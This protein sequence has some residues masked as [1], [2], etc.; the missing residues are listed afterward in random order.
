[1]EAVIAVSPLRVTTPTLRSSAECRWSVASPPL[2][3]SRES[4]RRWGLAAPLFPF[5]SPSPQ[6]P[7][8]RRSN[9]ISSP[10]AAMKSA[11]AAQLTAGKPLVVVGSANADVYV[12]VARM[13]LAGETVSATS[14]CTLPG[15]KGA[16]QAAAGARLG[17]PT[18][19]IGQVGS[20]ANGAMMSAALASTGVHVD[21]LVTLGAPASASSSAAMT[22]A[23]PCVVA[24]NAAKAEA[25]AALGQ[26]HAAAQRA[27]QAA[28]TASR[29]SQAAAGGNFRTGA[30]S[31]AAATAQAEAEA[32]AA[33]QRAAS[34]AARAAAEAAAAAD[35]QSE[36]AARG[37]AA[38]A[39]SAATAAANMTG[40]GGDGSVATGQAIV[41]LQADGSNAIIIVGGANMA[42]SK[43]RVEGRGGGRRESFFSEQAREA[44]RG[45]GMVLL[46]RELPDD[47]NAEAA[48]LA[49]AAGVPVVLDMGGMDG[50]LPDAMLRRVAVMSPNETEL[51]RLTG[52]PVSSIPDAERAALTLLAKGV[53]KVLVKL[54]SS[55]SLLVS[56]SPLAPASSSSP[57]SAT[58]TTGTDGSGR[59]V[60]Q[61][62]QPVVPA[63]TVVDTTGAGDT[64]TAAY[65]VALLSGSSDADAL[66]FASC[67]A[68]LCV[69]KK[70]AMPSLP[71]RAAV[72]ALVQQSQNSCRIHLCPS[73]R[74]IHCHILPPV[75]NLRGLVAPSPLHISAMTAAMPASSL[76]P[77]ARRWSFAP[78]AVLACCFSASPADREC[79][80][81]HGK[82]QR[83]VT[84]LDAGVAVCDPSAHAHDRE[85]RNIACAQSYNT[86][87]VGANGV[88]KFDGSSSETPDAK[89]AVGSRCPA[90]HADARRSAT[91]GAGSGKC[92]DGL[93]GEGGRTRLSRLLSSIRRKRRRQPG[94][95]GGQ[96]HGGGQRD[97]E[98]RV[99]GDGGEPAPGPDEARDVWEAAE[100]GGLSAWV[101]PA[102][103]AANAATAALGDLV[104]GG[105]RFCFPSH[106]TFP[107]LA[108]LS[109]SRSVSSAHD[110]AADSSRSRGSVLGRNAS[111]ERN[112]GGES[113]RAGASQ[114]GGA[115]TGDW[116]KSERRGT[117]V[118]QESG[119]REDS[120][121]EV[122]GQSTAAADSEGR[123]EE[124]VTRGG[125]EGGAVT[126]AEAGERI[127]G[128]ICDGD[129]GADADEGGNSLRAAEMGSDG[130]AGGGST[131]QARD[132]EECG[133]G[134]NASAAGLEKRLLPQEAKGEEEGSKESKAGRNGITGGALEGS[135]G[136]ATGNGARRAGKPVNR[137]WHHRGASEG[138]GASA[139]PS[140][141]S[142]AVSA[143]PMPPLPPRPQSSA[144]VRDGKGGGE[145]AR[146]I[147]GGGDVQVLRMEWG[148]GGEAGWVVRHGRQQ[149]R[150]LQAQQEEEE[151]AHVEESEEVHAVGEGSTHLHNS[152]SGSGGWHGAGGVDTAAGSGGGSNRMKA[153]SGGDGREACVRH[154]R[155]RSMAVSLPSSST[156]VHVHPFQQ[157]VRMFTTASTSPSA[158]APPA[159]TASAAPV[160]ADRACVRSVGARPSTEG[161]P[162]HTAEAGAPMLQASPRVQML[163]RP[164]S[165]GGRRP[166]CSC[167]SCSGGSGG[168]MHHSAAL[169]APCTRD[170]SDDKSAPHSQPW[171]DSGQALEPPSA[172]EGSGLPAL[173]AGPDS[174]VPLAPCSPVHSRG[175]VPRSASGSAGRSNILRS[176]SGSSAARPV[177]RVAESDAHST[178]SPTTFHGSPAPTN[179]S[180]MRPPLAAVP[181]EQGVAGGGRS[182][183]AQSGM[184][185]QGRTR[186]VRRWASEDFRD[187]M[188]VGQSPG[189]MPQAG[190]REAGSG[191]EREAGTVRS[192]APW[193]SRG[194]G[195]DSAG[196]L[197]QQSE[198]M[199]EERGS[200]WAVEGFGSPMGSGD[201]AREQMGREQERR[202]RRGVGQRVSRERA[203][204][205]VDDWEDPE[206]RNVGS[207]DIETGGGS[208]HAR[209]GAGPRVV[210]SRRL[211][212][213]R[214]APIKSLEHVVVGNMAGGGDGDGDG[215]SMGVSVDVGVGDMDEA[216]LD[217][218]DVVMERVVLS[219]A[220]LASL[221]HG[222]AAGETDGLLLGRLEQRTTAV[223]SDAQG[224]DG[225][226][227]RN[228]FCLVVTGFRSAGR[229]LSFYDGTGTVDLDRV[230]LLLGSS[231]NEGLGVAGDGR[232]NTV[233][234]TAGS[235]AG[236]HECV[237][238]W[239]VR[240]SNSPLQPSMREAAVTAQ[241][242]DLRQALQSGDSQK[243]QASELRN[244]AEPEGHGASGFKDAGT[245]LQRDRGQLTLLPDMC[246]KRWFSKSIRPILCIFNSQWDST[247]STHTTHYLAYAL[248]PEFSP[249]SS[250]SATVSNRLA[251]LP[252][253]ISVANLGLA[254]RP[255]FPTFLSMA[256][257][258]VQ[259]YPLCSVVSSTASDCNSQ[260]LQ[261][262][263]LQHKGRQQVAAFEAVYEGTL[264]RLEA[265]A[266]AAADSTVE[267][268]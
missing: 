101:V 154:A 28:A 185:R 45:A 97:A 241:L 128:A 231:E 252:L 250:I 127:V 222:L 179:R 144:A 77:P 213:H 157:R 85:D 244:E 136:A 139:R 205:V 200:R 51:S 34:A 194:Q 110:A 197:V 254:H 214:S 50:P 162:E 121:W 225:Q 30:A 8:A 42:W 260:H 203:T 129:A 251:L 54:G 67:A 195:M 56:S 228:D 167:L 119:A 181:W 175:A 32:A 124:G 188:G 268:V 16:N 130:P 47:V 253:P 243:H 104:M 215:V 133:D 120:T 80:G 95:R 245:R 96:P 141:S 71:D 107:P 87:S 75:D 126:V 176:S 186:K 204:G 18:Y 109:R 234:S 187:A 226:I 64:F 227:S 249:T 111:F 116:E 170:R 177:R 192:S 161:W 29:E 155:S 178:N 19:L 239:F 242:D 238:G 35:G 153:G 92:A 149:R 98:R 147:Q 52:L 43:R 145:G 163:Q 218:L 90:P 202:M 189:S 33:A 115:E 246:M 41:M 73:P 17:H 257:P 21:H 166:N 209:V 13:P 105:G 7:A 221:V 165:A 31:A 100:T 146:A 206:C 86:H 190:G 217:Y 74:D 224:D 207:V 131:C 198:W 10:R 38:A 26:A 94:S 3:R 24:A 173:D 172:H 99:G 123:E 256:L 169:L 164:H 102:V 37:A 22:S 230:Q 156:L 258:S 14:G 83:A 142:G 263:E 103:A 262:E 183:V 62:R 57:L 79:A 240:R 220:T 158:H 81:N 72:Q 2:V 184:G 70:G 255:S 152:A 112:A 82:P 60:W 261:W 208:G 247:R 91:A 20:D 174:L 265:S 6:P 113:A 199:G 5:R 232:R 211:Q 48:E 66:L 138:E 39:A 212:K 132:A 151:E 11:R 69:Q 134:E 63:R 148:S 40:G 46:Q 125:Q 201:E 4:H 78:T 1:M 160:P 196:E 193:A 76:D 143:S 12:E 219:G 108:S 15:G 89:G 159:L 9:L 106:R 180:P 168:A 68:S 93:A 23:H 49:G 58:L 264:S 65:A 61:L 135:A 267:L 137:A 237:I 36:A 53:P 140:S 150:Q 259:P 182:G 223:Y 191:S 27:Q 88:S 248:S 122:E 235:W 25:E 84:S 55:G 171:G 266:A 118:P 233:A 117:D 59:H 236:P 114:G 210:G 229:V 216:D 44:I